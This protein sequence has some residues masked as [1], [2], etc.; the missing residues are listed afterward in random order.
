MIPPRGISAS[1]LLGFSWE[2]CACG[3][4][5]RDIDSVWDPAQDR[6]FHVFCWEVTWRRRR[7]LG[8]VFPELNL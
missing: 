4:H 1:K 2:L 7:L 5:V 8:E 6:Y 3:G